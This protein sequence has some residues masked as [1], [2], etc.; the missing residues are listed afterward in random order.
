M[1]SLKD[2]GKKALSNLKS[3]TFKIENVE[4]KASPI[5]GNVGFRVETDE[6]KTITFWLSNMDEVVELTDAATGLYTV[7]PGTRVAADGGLIPASAKA[8]GF[9]DR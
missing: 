6:G 7:I 5:T 1:V 3:L 4:S 2:L 9:W 8:G